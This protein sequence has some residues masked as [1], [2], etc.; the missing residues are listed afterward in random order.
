MMVNNVFLS[1]T[2][3]FT[4]FTLASNYYQKY[5]SFAEFCC[6]LQYCFTTNSYLYYATIVYKFYNSV[7]FDIEMKYI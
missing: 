6:S 4:V 5:I 7:C 2:Q 1:Q 3:N